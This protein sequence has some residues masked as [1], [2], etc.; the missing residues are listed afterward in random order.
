MIVLWTMENHTKGFSF[1]LS[2]ALM[3]GIT[4][5]FEDYIYVPA[6][7]NIVTCIAAIPI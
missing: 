3:S 2:G 5:S 7:M 6:T 4:N 1:F